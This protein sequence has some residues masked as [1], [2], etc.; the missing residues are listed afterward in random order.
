MIESALVRIY[1]LLGQ[2]DTFELLM[3]TMESVGDPCLQARLLEELIPRIASS[4][5]HRQRAVA[6]LFRADF[7]PSTRTRLLL[8]F[9]INPLEPSLLAKAIQ[10]A[11]S[12][13][14]ATALPLLTEIAKAIGRSCKTPQSA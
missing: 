9:A 14:R 1:E 4:Y 12:L 7:D 8:K 11:T 6:I 3:T 10:S 13:P 2:T 5:D